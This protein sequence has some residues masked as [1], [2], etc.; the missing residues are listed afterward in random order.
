MNEQHLHGLTT[1][2]D[3]NV[4]SDAVSKISQGNLIQLNFASP[5]N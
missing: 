1:Q 5:V 2:E 4:S 3:K